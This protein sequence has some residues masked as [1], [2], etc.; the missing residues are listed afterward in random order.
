[1]L[2]P[3]D[4]VITF[5]AQMLM[6]YNGEGDETITNGGYSLGLGATSKSRA[7]TF[8]PMPELLVLDNTKVETLT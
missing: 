3:R 5:N 2:V 7:L 1:M 4:V 6:L 8:Y